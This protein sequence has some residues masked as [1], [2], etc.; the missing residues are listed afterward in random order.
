MVCDYRLNINSDDI[1]KFAG[2]RMAVGEHKFNCSWA[3]M[4]GLGVGTFPLVFQVFHDR[5]SEFV[6]AIQLK[7]FILSVILTEILTCSDFFI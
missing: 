1:V 5:K 6:F 3:Y 2:M 7:L 4:A